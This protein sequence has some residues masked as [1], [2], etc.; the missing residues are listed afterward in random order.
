[1]PPIAFLADLFYSFTSPLMRFLYSLIFSFLLTFANAQTPRL[2]RAP[3]D[4]VW[5]QA[6]LSK[7]QIADQRSHLRL[8]ALQASFCH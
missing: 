8:G 4:F 2:T 5:F 7:Y 3:E 6:A 1:M